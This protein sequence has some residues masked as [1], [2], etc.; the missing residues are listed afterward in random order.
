MKLRPFELALITGFGLLGLL[1]IGLLATYKPP[2]DQAAVTLGSV[3]EIWGTA[4]AGAFNQVLRPIVE[5]QDAYRA[6]S[7]VQKS[8]DTFD[9]DLLNALAEDRGPDMIFMTH[10][11]L[12]QYRSKLQPV[13]YENFPLRDFRNLYIDGAEIFART[14]GLYAYPIA[15]D[16]IV[17]Y[18]N[19]DI[20]A[21]KNLLNAPATWESVVNDIVPAFVERD[22]NRTITR[23]PVAFGE[24]RNVTNATEVLAMLTIQGGSS[25]VEEGT[26]GRYRILLN[27]S[28]GINRGPLENAL[29]FYTNFSSPSNPLYSWN[30]ARPVD[31][32][33]FLS[34]DLVLYFGKGSEA[35]DLESQNPNLN[36][37]IAE[38]PQGATATIRRTYG[39]FYGLGIMRA[40]DN[41]Q[42]AY[43]ALQLLGGSQFATAWANNLG[44]A[45]AHRQTLLAGSNDTYGRIIYTAAISARGWLSPAPSQVD[46]IFTEMVEDVLANR[47]RSADAANDAVGRMSQVY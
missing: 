15:I 24:V 38:V 5:E 33:A 41:K 47:R 10:E 13:A 46:T 16:P 23:S 45:P 20:L 14:D 19:R 30:R 3:V 36:F 40:S 37:D 8:P 6:I 31:R 35:R 18:W 4:D 1:A 7:Y 32:E 43:L 22:F 25:L 26:D 34:E 21:T 39:E 27:Q 44:M 2:A 29:T 9:A 17:M 28:A 11:Q 42:G 12:V